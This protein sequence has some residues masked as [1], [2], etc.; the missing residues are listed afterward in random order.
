MAVKVLGI[1]GSPRRKGNTELL[2]D[3]ALAG[4]KS[5]GAEVEKLIL[6]QLHITPC[7][8]CG[9][10]AET[11]ECAIQDDMVLVYPKLRAADCLILASPIYFSSLTA[12]T[13]A[14]IDR[15]QCLWAAKYILGCPI[16][17]EKRRGLFISTAAKDSDQFLAAISIVKAFF[18][19]VDVGYDAA[20]LFHGIEEKGEITSHP[21]ALKQAFAAGSGL[22]TQDLALVSGDSQQITIKPIGWVRNEIKQL[23]RRQW[24]EVESEI[25]LDPTM[26]EALD[27]VEEFSHI[28]VIFWM[29]KV[30]V[31]NIPLK[32]HPQG[33]QEFPL[34]GLFATHAPYRPNPIGVT[35]VKLLKRKGNVLRVKGLDAIDGTPVLDIKSY[36]PSDSITQVGAPDW[37]RKCHSP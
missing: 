20:L 6:N 9:K 22:I 12:Q 2:L 31:K 27:G 4:A 1:S 10:C 26:T 19:T 25:I 17:N 18:A 5:E 15:C 23:P 13:K 30:F 37:V 24:K 32:I 28:I 21:T 16:A 29:H 34:V 7:Q 14:M 11:G 36:F 3:E 35:V 8:G 33:R